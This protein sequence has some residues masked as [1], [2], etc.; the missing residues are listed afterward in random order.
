MKKYFK[1]LAKIWMRDNPDRP[2]TTNDIACFVGKALHLEKTPNN[3][4]F[5]FRVSGLVPFN[6]LIFENDL[7]FSCVS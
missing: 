7:D 2:M 6:L 4:M 5:G 3:I 1:N